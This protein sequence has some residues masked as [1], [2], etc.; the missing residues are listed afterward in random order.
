M[1]Y[2]SGVIAE[3][4]QN[5]AA[6]VVTAVDNACSYHYVHTTEWTQLSVFDNTQD[7]LSPQLIETAE[8][9][10]DL[11][12]RVLDAYIHQCTAEAQEGKCSFCSLFFAHLSV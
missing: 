10:A 2:I 8:K 6:S 9:S 5:L 12:P 3:Y 7:E 1:A 4:V 11:D